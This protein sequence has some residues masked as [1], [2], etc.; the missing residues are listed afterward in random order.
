MSRLIAPATVANPASAAPTSAIVVRPMNSRL[1]PNASG[2]Q[3]QAGHG[4]LPQPGSP[5]RGHSTRSL[6]EA[7]DQPVSCSVSSAGTLLPLG[8][9]RRERGLDYLLPNE[10]ELF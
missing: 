4:A 9:L 7:T 1:T 6:V 10:V 8:R 3:L 5:F 2:A